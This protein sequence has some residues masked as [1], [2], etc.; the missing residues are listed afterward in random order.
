M[1]LTVLKSGG[2]FNAGH[3]RRLQAQCARFAPNAGFACMSDEWIDG[4]ERIP[5]VEGWPGW[6][7]KMELFRV[8][9]PILYMDLDTTIVGDLEPLLQVV[10]SRPFIALRDFNP[11]ARALGSGLMG[12][13]GNLM[14]LYCVFKRQAEVAMRDFVTAKRW[15][16]QGWI[17]ENVGVRSYWQELLPGAVVSFKKDVAGRGVPK[18][19]RVVCF[20]GKPRPWEVPDVVFR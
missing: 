4:V 15:G 20:H 2:D 11:K 9:G 17:D 14:D 7:S 13:S 18:A 10:R 6:W 3:V 1:I 16:D 8:A 19:A 12:W 5:L